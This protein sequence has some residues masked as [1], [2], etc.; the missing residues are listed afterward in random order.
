MWPPRGVEAT[1]Q[2]VREAYKSDPTRDWEP[3]WDIDA[4]LDHAREAIVKSRLQA[5]RL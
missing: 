5:E 2:R 1:S 3:V 4:S